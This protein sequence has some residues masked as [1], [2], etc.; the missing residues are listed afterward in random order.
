[1]E[2]EESGDDRSLVAVEAPSGLSRNRIA[3]AVAKAGLPAF[4]SALDQVA[5]GV[6]HYLVEL[7]G[8]I[9]DGDKRLAELAV[10][11]ELKSGG[12]AAIGAYAVPAGAS[13]LGTPA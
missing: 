12:V 2:P 1:M 13:A 4:T 8:I 9:S 11:L 10:A 7:P 5:G 3:G 6:H